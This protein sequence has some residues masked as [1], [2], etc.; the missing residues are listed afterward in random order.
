MMGSD[1]CCRQGFRM[2]CFI[3]ACQ[4]LGSRFFW[5]LRRTG[6]FLLFYGGSECTRFNVCSCRCSIIGVV[7]GVCSALPGLI[8]RVYLW[9]LKR[10]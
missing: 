3:V 8:P 5:I 9:K 6:W 7:W 2:L 10:W 1:S 4:V